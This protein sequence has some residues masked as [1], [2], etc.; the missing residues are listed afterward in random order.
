MKEM[1][2]SVIILG[3]DPGIGITGYSVLQDLGNRVEIMDYGA[4]RTDS[5]V[6][7]PER[8]C[9]LYRCI[10]ELI[11]RFHPEELAMEELFFN[12]NVKT[13]LLVGQAMG[14]IT[15]AC[16]RNGLSI[17]KYTPLQVKQAVAGY[18]RA[19]KSQVQQMVKMLL[20]LSEVPKPDD[21]A[22]ALAVGL[23]HV[24]SRTLMNRV[25]EQKS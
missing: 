12:K 25:N 18:G 19:D 21:V 22:D 6:C 10:E 17:T 16:V 8:L 23:C 7:F 15:L 4:I 5:K 1:D 24:N 9:E 3:I 14:V 11:A 13:A 20:S 2:T